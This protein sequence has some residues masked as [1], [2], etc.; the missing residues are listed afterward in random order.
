MP[1]LTV[2]QPEEGMTVLRQVAEER[3]VGPTSNSHSDLRLILRK[4]SSF[5]V[6]KRIP[7]TDEVELGE[8]GLRTLFGQTA[9]TGTFRTRWVS[10]IPERRAGRGALQGVLTVSSQHHF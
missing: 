1:A 6:V 2:E 10:P 3:K 9:L 8:G 4:A 5:S 7:E